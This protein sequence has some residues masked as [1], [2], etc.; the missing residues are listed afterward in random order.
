MSYAEKNRKDDI[1]KKVEEIQNNSLNMIRNIVYKQIKR[2]TEKVQTNKKK[3]INKYLEEL[4]KITEDNDIELPD[5]R[6]D[7]RS[8]IAEI[9]DRI[10]SINKILYKMKKIKKNEIES[11]EKILKKYATTITKNLREI[12][13]NL[14]H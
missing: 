8:L 12:A 6:S 14:G 5:T 2:D 9:N 10:D 3:N 13:A 1:L 4:D 11:L 7:V